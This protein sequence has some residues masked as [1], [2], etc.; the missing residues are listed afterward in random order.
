MK[1][2]RMRKIKYYFL[3]II[4][5]VILISC[6]NIQP[7]S[8]GPKDTIPPSVSNY[9][10]NDLTT[11]FNDSK[12]IIDFTKWV[13]RNSV[14]QNIS[15]SPPV[16]LKYSWSGKEL[17][18]DFQ[19][20]L[21]KNTT[22]SFLLGTEYTDLK[23]NKPDSA[24]AI[25]FS[26]GMA[27]DSGKIKGIIYGKKIAGT[28]IYGYKID[29]MNPD[30]LNIET[31]PAEYKTQ[32]GSNGLFTVRALP[33]GKYRIFA[34][35]TDFK[36]N[37]FHPNSDFFGTSQNDII[38]KNG[39]AE[40]VK[41]KIEKY[42]NMQPLEVIENQQF[43]DSLLQISLNKPFHII[44]RNIENFVELIDSNSNTKIPIEKIFLDSTIS[45][46]L[47]LKMKESLSNDKR[48]ILNFLADSLLKDT[49]NV[50]SQK[51][52]YIFSPN[53]TVQLFNFK[54]I[55]APL[56]DS[57][58]NVKQEMNYQFVFNQPITIDTNAKI[59]EMKDLI[60]KR[61]INI[62]IEQQEPNSL[63]IIPL[64][65][66]QPINWY[67]LTFNL[68]QI[69]NYDAQ[70]IKDTTLKYD[71]QTEDWRANVDISGKLLD[72]VGC[73]HITLKLSSENGKEQY[74][75]KIQNQNEWKFSNIKPDTYILEAFCDE[76]QNGVYDY[77]QEFPYKPSEKFKKFANKIEVKPRWNIENIMLLFDNK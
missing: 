24:F 71:F 75:A 29:N 65:E 41:I 44:A 10:P 60:G 70:I 49:S 48:Y 69:K 7:P 61:E 64:E 68:G 76:N 2:K 57:L 31:T 62:K 30:T 67:R 22:Y 32:V 56:K 16:E 4:L 54:I 17:E 27:I 74:F 55:Y 51:I 77:G 37:L 52:K 5:S 66:L 23:N 18:I 36:D 46:N 58:K 25:T 19:D 11:N 21:K 1:K 35:T 45:T 53:F 38:V 20:N 40:D 28:L 12:I 26:T 9:K 50:F 42:P 14:I 43:N 59:A 8:G 39:I 15:I 72:S 47:Y 33:D 63:T 3:P 13:N 6:A 73:S 34:V